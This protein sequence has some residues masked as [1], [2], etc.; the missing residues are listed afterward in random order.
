MMM[1]INIQWVIQNTSQFQQNIID[2]AISLQKHVMLSMTCF[3]LSWRVTLHMC[4][5]AR[6]VTSKSQEHGLLLCNLKQ[7]LVH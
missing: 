3:I 4:L 1:Y 7:G 5:G 6:R 2:L